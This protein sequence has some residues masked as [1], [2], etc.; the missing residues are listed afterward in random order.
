MYSPNDPQGNRKK[1]RQRRA[2]LKKHELKLEEV[3][4]L[5]DRL[6]IVEHWEM[7]SLARQ[8]LAERVATRDY[9]LALDK[10]ESLVVARIFELTKMNMSQTGKD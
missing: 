10:L 1:E 2:I 7:G 4:A 3:V 9:R 5:E 8:E 6:Y